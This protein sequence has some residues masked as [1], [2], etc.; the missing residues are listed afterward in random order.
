MKRVGSQEISYNEPLAIND[1]SGPQSLPE[2]KKARRAA[3]ERDRYWKYEKFV[4]FIRFI[5]HCV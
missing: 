5:S 1:H 2:R 4:T 3:A